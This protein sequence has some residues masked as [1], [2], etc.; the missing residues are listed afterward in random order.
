MTP[1]TLSPTSALLIA[2]PV[3]LAL[4]LFVLV[5]FASQRSRSPAATRLE[6]D[7]RRSERESRRFLRRH[8]APSVGEP[9]AIEPA[10]PPA[11][12][13]APAGVHAE[14]AAAAPGTALAV[15]EQRLEV[16][17]SAAA[18]AALARAEEARL[19]VPPLPARDPEQAQLDRRQFLNRGIV[20]GSALGLGLFG[21]ASIAFLYP[22]LGKGFGGKVNGGKVQDALDYFKAN[23]A[24]LYVAEGRFYV[25][26]FNVAPQNQ[27]QAKRTYTLTYDMSK[28]TGVMV[29]YQK[30]AHLGCRVP[31][32]DV[33]QW[34]EC[35]CHG[36][37]YNAMG[38][39]QGGPAPR[40]LSR[41]AFTV[42]NG[43]IV[44]DTGTPLDAPPIGINS[45]GLP[46][47]PSHCVGG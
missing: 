41:F 42:S 16:G 1:A 4:F 14:T 11:D 40:G 10:P 18:Q 29:I 37:Q 38:E 13:V 8:G 43:E 9:P 30:C 28:Q 2:A 27:D 21:V 7:A 26:P 44:A 5:L 22:K 25:V 31:W 46:P 20:G 6:K 36:S 24:P 35:P 39:K 47:P 3:A 45:P 12:E 23:R 32:C 33:S 19:V 34:F 15:A 17:P